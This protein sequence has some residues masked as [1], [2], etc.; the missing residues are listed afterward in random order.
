[1]RDP[2]LNAF[3]SS[4]DKPETTQ[5][6][7]L[8]DGVISPGPESCRAGALF[9]AFNCSRRARIGSGAVWRDSNQKS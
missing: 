4:L 3:R 6:S 9:A 8:A 2:L 5:N 1:M 7:V